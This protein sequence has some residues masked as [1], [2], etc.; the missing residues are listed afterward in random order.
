M[1]FG[2]SLFSY[3]VPTREPFPCHLP[4][5]SHSCD[6][7]GSGWQDFGVPSLIF[8]LPMARE[9]NQLLDKSYSVACPARGFDRLQWGRLCVVGI[10]ACVGAGGGDFGAGRWGLAACK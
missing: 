2:A 4:A 7:A 6:L 3:L 5:A 8:F 10:A 1:R 9:P